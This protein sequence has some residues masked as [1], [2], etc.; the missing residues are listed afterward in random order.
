[1]FQNPLISVIMSVHNG[2]QFLS[3]SIESI[4]KQTVSD[5]EFIIIDDGSTDSSSESL[6]NT[7][8]WMRALFG[9]VGSR[10]DLLSRLMRR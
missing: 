2:A 8:R 9:G 1:M 6:G 7:Q 5:F 10:K 3:L 4:L